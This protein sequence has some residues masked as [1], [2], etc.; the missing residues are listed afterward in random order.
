MLNLEAHSRVSICRP[1]RGSHSL[2]TSIPKACAVGYILSPLRGFTLRAPCRSLFYLPLQGLFQTASNKC[3]VEEERGRFHRFSLG[4][5]SPS[6]LK[7]PACVILRPTQIIR[8]RGD[9]L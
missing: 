1:S 3:S 7:S 4:T 8:M 6:S 2:S 5:C 9:G